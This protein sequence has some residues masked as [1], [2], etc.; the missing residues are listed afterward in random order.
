MHVLW[1]GRGF[2]LHWR[3][4]SSAGS[5]T[6]NPLHPLLD[7]ASR[8]DPYPLLAQLR[9]RSPLV[10]ANGT[11]IVADY[12]GCLEVMKNPAMGSDTMAAPSLAGIVSAIGRQEVTES[13]FF[14]NPPDHGRQRGLISKAFTP[15]ITAQYERWIESIVEELLSGFAERE[16]IDAV[17]DFA[18]VLPLRVI[19]ELFDIA[20]GD[21]EMLKLWSDELA[22]ATEL[23]TLVAGFRS[24]QMFSEQDLAGFA[25]V[26]VAAHAYFADLIHKRRKKPGDDLVS[27]LLRT[28]DQGRTLARHEVTNALVTLFAAAHESVTNLISNGLLELHRHPDQ[29]A[30]LRARPEI[31][32]L[33]VD[34]V[35]RH[36]A[37]VHVTARVALRP[38]RIGDLPIEADT[39]VLLLLAA[40]N[41]DED[42]YPEADRFIADRRTTSMSLSFGA[43]AHYCIGSS[44]ARLE[45]QIALTALA[46]RLGDFAVD[47]ESLVYRRHVVVRGLQSMTFRRVARQPVATAP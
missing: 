47:E 38:T 36:D 16:S 9:A 7:P 19:C 37:P 13:I 45:A 43:G 44:L 24:T 32:P 2:W 30:L 27:S 40:G 46:E 12:R 34:E 28:E 14:M 1:R 31:A 6:D 15:R 5:L 20:P 41:R 22:L 17:R 26:A 21:A 23:P 4:R 18:A 39:I 33:L 25:G 42:E 29:L 8:P 10:A 35:L 11:V 3:V